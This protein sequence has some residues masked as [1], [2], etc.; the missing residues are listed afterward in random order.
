MHIITKNEGTPFYLLLTF[1]IFNNCL[2]KENTKEIEKL[3]N[4]WKVKKIYAPNT[5]F[6]HGGDTYKWYN[7][8]RINDNIFKFNIKQGKSKISFLVRVFTFLQHLVVLSLYFTVLHTYT[9]SYPGN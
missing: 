5:C 9:C 2:S 8:S 7:E 4:S 1:F 6:W 3:L